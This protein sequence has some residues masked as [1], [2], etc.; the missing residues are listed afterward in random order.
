MMVVITTLL[1]FVI[2]PAIVGWIWA[3]KSFNR[4]Y[5]YRYGKYTVKS[6]NP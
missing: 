4:K 6:R 5:R 1:L 2:L 3:V